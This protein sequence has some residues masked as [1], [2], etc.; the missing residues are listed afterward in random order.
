MSEGDR[1]WCLRDAAVRVICDRGHWETIG[2]LRLVVADWQ[3]MRIVHRTPF[4]RP[5]L[6]PDPRMYSNA[7]ALA[8]AEPDLAYVLEIWTYPNMLEH[9]WAE[10]LHVQWSANEAEKRIVSFKAGGW[11]WPLIKA[12]V[13]LN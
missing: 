7:L 10:V 11:E 2:G 9:V 6:F 4:Q 1:V 12:W 8:T 3:A 13:A 5:P